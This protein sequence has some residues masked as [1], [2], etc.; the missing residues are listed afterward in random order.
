MRF[1]FE[2]VPCTWPLQKVFK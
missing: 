2:S 1:L